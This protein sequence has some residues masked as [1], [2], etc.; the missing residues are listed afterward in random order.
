MA[1]TF[2]HTMNT[3]LIEAGTKTQ[4]P[5]KHWVKYFINVKLI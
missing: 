4:L 2:D 5:M 3:I 1:G